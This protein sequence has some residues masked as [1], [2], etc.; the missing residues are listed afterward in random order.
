MVL[1]I[2]AGQASREEAD[3]WAIRWVAAANPPDMDPAIWRALGKLAGCDLRH[4]P[5]NDYL[6][7]SA[8]IAEWL[9]DLRDESAI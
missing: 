2:L 3:R 5:G 1:A 9:E 8:Q 7:S 6:H 4:G